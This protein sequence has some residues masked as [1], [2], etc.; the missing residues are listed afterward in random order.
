MHARPKKSMCMY[1]C[2]CVC[3]YT[4]TRMSVYIYRQNSIKNNSII[5]IKVSHNIVI[6]SL[7]HQLYI[8]KSSKIILW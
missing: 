4:Y 5:Y 8:F 3:V 2:M 7:L 6:E 1:M